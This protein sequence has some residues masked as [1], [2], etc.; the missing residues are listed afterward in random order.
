MNSGSTQSLSPSHL[1]PG[2]VL[3]YLENSFSFIFAQNTSL[4]TYVSKSAFRAESKVQAVHA[5]PSMY[6]APG[7]IPSTTKRKKKSQTS[8]LWGHGKTPHHS[9]ANRQQLNIGLSFWNHF[10]YVCCWSPSAISHAS[11]P[12]SLLGSQQHRTFFLGVIL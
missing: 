2:V 9:L 8:V 6:K 3:S 12:L 5:L 7:S 1:T 11:H 4:H 10:A